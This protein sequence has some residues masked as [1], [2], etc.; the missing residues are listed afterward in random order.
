MSRL[1]TCP[2]RQP[3][4]PKKGEAEGSQA[5]PNQGPR[6]LGTRHDGHAE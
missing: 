5:R 4:P 2:D 1:D 6:L 3:Q